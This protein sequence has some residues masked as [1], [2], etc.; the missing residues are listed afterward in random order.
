MAVS[1]RSDFPH[2]KRA[3]VVNGASA[4]PALAS[5][6]QEK[7]EV[8]KYHAGKPQ[9]GYIWYSMSTVQIHVGLQ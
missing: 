3:P 7:W 1:S 9:F 4:A 8:P 6:H 2:E 5:W